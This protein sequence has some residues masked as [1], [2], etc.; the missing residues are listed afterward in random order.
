MHDSELPMQLGSAGRCESPGRVHW[1]RA[2]KHNIL[3][4]FKAS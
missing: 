3:I 4:L 1:Q 2:G